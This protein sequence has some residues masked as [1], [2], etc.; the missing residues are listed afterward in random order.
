M[1]KTL[2]GTQAPAPALTLEGYSPALQA[3]LAEAAAAW[4][5]WLEEHG[6]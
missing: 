1:P 5:F 3:A 6:E 2:R 4:A